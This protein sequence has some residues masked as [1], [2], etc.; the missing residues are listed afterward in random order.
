MS[1]TRYRK[2]FDSIS[3]GS[4]IIPLIGEMRFAQIEVALDSASCFVRELALTEKVI[5]PLPLGGDH[6]KF[7]FIVKLSK[8][9]VPIIGSIFA[10]ASLG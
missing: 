5:R 9:L 7:D 3:Y 4:G 8:F 10:R 1:A 6:Q 2:R